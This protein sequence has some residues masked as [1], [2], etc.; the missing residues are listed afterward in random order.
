MKGSAT[1]SS[2]SKKPEEGDAKPTSKGNLFSKCLQTPLL[3]S[4]FPKHCLKAWWNHIKVS[5]K[6]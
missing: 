1:R 6:V 3:S 2:R 4:S 5:G